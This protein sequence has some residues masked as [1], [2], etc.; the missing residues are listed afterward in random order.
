MERLQ[1]SELAVP[2]TSS[3]FFDNARRGQADAIFLDLED[4]IAPN[5]RIEA[6]E[7]AVHAL[8]NYDWGNKTMS[9]RVNGLGTPYAIG[10]II[11]IARCARLDMLMIPKVEAPSDVEFVDRLLAGLE[12]EKPR[13][14]PVGIEI[15]VETTKGLANVEALAASAPGRL[16]AMIFGVGDYSIELQNYDTVFGAPNPDYAMAADQ[17]GGP[18][19]SLND[20]WHF[21]LA[22][23]A[24]A[25]R[26][27]GLRPVDGP[28]ANYGDG[29]AYRAAAQRSRALG[30]EGKWAIHPSQ[31]DIANE[32]YRP[33]EAQAE[34]AQ[35]VL[36]RMRD[37]E[38]AGN[39]AFGLGDVL[40][41]Q[42][43][44]TLARNIERRNKLVG[45]A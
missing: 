27:Y 17:A 5:R 28:F 41:D 15:L 30:F 40:I 29:A 21:A 8:H 43:H 23:I 39:G 36:D 26:A 32:V 13:E 14:R 19:T 45:E 24:N 31:I 38:A 10:D 33:T 12:L 4:A 37:A 9:V 25:C 35:A 2:A 16:E 18:F 11:A 20:P 22:R 34:W 7:M 6:R 42:A 44:V 3:K 1:R